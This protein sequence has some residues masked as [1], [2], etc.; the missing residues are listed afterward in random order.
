MAAA[1]KFLSIDFDSIDFTDED[2]ADTVYDYMM[3]EF[4]RYSAYGDRVLE[5]YEK[6]EEITKLIEE[7]ED[8]YTECLILDGKADIHIQNDIFSYSI[9]GDDDK[10]IKMVQEK[11]GH[12]MLISLLTEDEKKNMYICANLSNLMVIPLK[13]IL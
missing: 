11:F 1:R 2:W 10:Y 12:E 8:Y 13:E 9:P 7:I 5:Q 6:Q 3:E 4:I